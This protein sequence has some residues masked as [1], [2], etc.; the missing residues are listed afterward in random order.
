MVCLRDLHSWA[1]PLQPARCKA[2]NAQKPAEEPFLF[3]LCWTQKW[4]QDERRQRY[5]WLTSRP[6]IDYVHMQFY[7]SHHVAPARKMRIPA[8]SVLGK[9]APIGRAAGVTMTPDVATPG[10]PPDCALLGLVFFCRT[11]QTCDIL[12]QQLSLYSLHSEW[13]SMQSLRNLKSCC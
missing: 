8:A 4:K 6:C 13:C 12:C 2:K 11:G 9:G 10:T 7:A 5:A 3:S 1:L